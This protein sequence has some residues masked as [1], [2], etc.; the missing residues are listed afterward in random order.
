VT[1]GTE[2]HLALGVPATVYAG[3]LNSD[4]GNGL[5]RVHLGERSVWHQPCAGCPCAGRI[6][7]SV[8]FEKSDSPVVLC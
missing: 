7:S 4:L 6:L 8:C 2:A 1:H 3:A 5:P